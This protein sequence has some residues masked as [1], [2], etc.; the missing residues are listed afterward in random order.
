MAIQLK[1]V[2]CTGSK[3][4]SLQKLNLDSVSG[5][6]VYA[7]WN[8]SNMVRIGQGDI[9]DRLLE[10][11]TNPQITRYGDLHVTWAIVPEHY[12]DG[13]ER[14]LADHYQPIEGD[15]FPQTQ[16]IAVNLPG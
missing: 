6:G 3:W 14:Y 12:R 13:V 1:W 15:R 7:I 11:R 9:A 2:K 5:E 10:H 8:Q 4:C 16:P